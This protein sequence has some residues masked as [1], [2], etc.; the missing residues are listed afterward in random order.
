[1]SSRIKIFDTTLRD[2]EQSP[3]CSM[4]LQEKL[5]V[6]AQ[7]EKLNVDIIEAGFAIASPGDFESVSEIAKV[8]KNATVAS[9]CRAVEQDIDRAY[10]AVKHAV[11]PR[12]H[13]FLATSPI[14]MKY[15]LKM[16]ED[17]VLE[18]TGQAVA[19]AKKYCNDIEFSAEDASRS[20]KAFLAKVFSRAIA[21]GAT[22]I[23]VPDTVGYS[24]PEEMAAYISYVKNNT[25]GIE[26][27]EISVHCHNDLGLAVSNTLASIKAGATQA[28]CTINGI[29]ERAGNTSLEEVVMNLRTR[30]DYYNVDCGIDS[31]Q[32][33]HSSKL[34][35]T[36]TG[37]PVA[38][39][40]A[41][42]GDNAFAHEAGIHQHGVL[43]ERT[44]YEIMSPQDIGIP[45]N[46]MVLGKH[47]GRHAL[48][49][50]LTELGYS[51]N[52]QE[53]DDTFARFK[54]LADKKKV[55]S[56][57]DLDA[58]VAMKLEPANQHYKLDNFV[59]NSGS[60]ITATATISLKVDN[61]IIEKVSGGDGPVDAAY[62]AIDSIIDKKI[63]LDDYS[64]R[65]VTEGEDALGEVIVKLSMDDKKTVGRGVSTDIIEASILAYLNGVNK[66]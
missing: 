17:E 9:L 44:T 32:I 66:L 58:L 27:A 55:V 63:Q 61:E 8:V 13:I 20:D 42:V 39:S 65:A 51:L 38:P 48:V 16:S 52:Q 23:N 35:Q 45:Q 21:N 24:S 43:A 46:K 57:S 19:Y 47:S 10:E 7:L 18:R 50:R 26:K 56:D 49:D 11:H 22:V 62:K 15:K 37:V 28:E 64:I 41:I 4:N 1:M 34:I 3:G 33:Y 2:G 12:I 6:A 40:K 30:K 59:I 54:I 60:K 31:R 25:D 53:I 14:H 29:G 5:E 36:I